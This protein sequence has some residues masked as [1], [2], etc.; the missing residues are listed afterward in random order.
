MKKYIQIIK[1]GVLASL[2]TGIT[3]CTDYLD[4]TS[5]SSISSTEAFKNFTNFQ[6]FT[7]EMYYCIPDFAKGYWT[8]S[9]NWGEDEIMNVGI[10]YHMCYKIDLGDF[11]GWQKEHDGWAAGWMDRN[12]VSTTNDD[13]FGKSLWPLAW[14]GIRKAN[15]GLANLHLMTDATDEERDLV[16]GQLYFFRG[17]FHFQLMQYLG[18]LPYIDEVLPSDQTLR[19]PRLNYHETAAHATEDFRRAA[20]LLPIDWDD[21]TA[22]K[23]TLGKNQL[24]INKIMALGYLGKNLLWAGSPLMNQESTGN[25]NYN[26]DLCRQAAEAFGGL[27]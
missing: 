4:K 13:R 18:G 10:D 22:G 1:Y 9:F 24:R 27:L 19:L 14:Y 17:W 8:N 2:M 16:E 6:G 5:D 23:R 20:D 12:Y 7:E 21:T 3:A 25:R 11:W 15:M 26:T